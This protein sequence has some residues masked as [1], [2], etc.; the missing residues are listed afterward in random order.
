MDPFWLLFL[1]FFAAATTATA[2]TLAGCPD[3]CGNITVPYPFGIAPDCFLAGFRL[4][5]DESSGQSKLFLGSKT[6]LVT[7]IREAD[8]IVEAP[9]AKNCY[10]PLGLGQD[11]LLTVID[12]TGT[13]YTLSYA[14]NKFTVLGCDSVGLNSQ[15]SDGFGFN[16][17]CMSLCK[18]TSVI[19]NGTCEG[20]GCC[21]VAI[22][23]GIQRLVTTV[24]PL[25]N[26]TTT[27]EFS[28]CSFAFLADQERFK[29]ELSDLYDF[30]RKSSIP[31][32]LDWGVGKRSC[33][34]AAGSPDYTCGSNSVCVNA[35][36]GHGYSCRCA[37]GYQGNPYL[38]DGCQD[39]DE[40]A[41]PATNPCSNICTNL[42]GGYACSCPK[43]TT[44]DGKKSGRGCVD[45]RKLPLIQIILGVGLSS[46]FLIAIGSWGYWALKK[47]KMILLR[48]NFFKQNGGFILQQRIS[49]LG[50]AASGALIFTAEEL[51]KAT[52]NYSTNRIL[53]IGGYGTVY[54][55]ILPDKR[56]VAIKRSKVVDETQ[57]E[58]FINEVVVLSQIIHRNVVKLIGC[59]LET[60][61]PLLVYEYVSNGTLTHHLHSD[62]RIASLSWDIRLRIAAETAAALA[63]LHS[64]T[65]LPI[66]HR[67]VKTANILLDEDFTA[68]VSDFGASRLIP[69]GRGQV[70]TLVQGTMGYL[71]PEYFQTGL[72]TESSDVYSFGV[73]LAELLTGEKPLCPARP[74]K[75]MN[76]AIHFLN[77]VEGNLLYSILEPRIRNEVRREQLEAVAA[78]TK[79]CL[80]LRGAERPS[81]KEIA[82]DLERLRTTPAHPWTLAPRSAANERVRERERLTSEDHLQYYSAIQEDASGRL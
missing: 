48:E 63:Y 78:M 54:K 33:E 26:H 29:F 79:R 77:A 55:G 16:S 75:E 37:N 41:D 71:D 65:A 5:C 24:S 42:P 50:S 43:G 74:Q 66:V 62:D 23:R 20:V 15:G 39:I 47:R 73:V 34:A 64:A 67:D 60:Q 81:M 49:S 1:Q 52:D 18:D 51:N 44:G 80:T 10:K 28:P 35:T 9:I 6:T 56:V 69:L 21:Q 72:L 57:V 30:A 68:K 45:S 61:V 22:P 8:L 4:T 32:V 82:A 3:R 14:K 38:A 36:S 2:T 12:V 11:L 40:C 25:R 46:L 70:T 7:E 19:T 58:Q 27:F 13:P 17:G 31:V 76:L 53:G 59:C